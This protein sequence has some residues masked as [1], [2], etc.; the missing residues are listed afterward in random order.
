MGA[1]F[2]ERAHETESLTL[3][4]AGDAVLGFVITKMLFDKYQEQEGCDVSAR[5]SLTESLTL[6]FAGS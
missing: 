2:H 5:R 6:L 3:L 4:S 1:T